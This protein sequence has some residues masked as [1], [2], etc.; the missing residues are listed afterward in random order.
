MHLTVRGV[1]RDL[2]MVIMAYVEGDD[3][4]MLDDDG[5]GDGDGW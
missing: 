2:V 1:P 5:C 3:D 4:G